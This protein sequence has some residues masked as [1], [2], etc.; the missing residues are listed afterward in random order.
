MMSNLFQSLTF[1]LY[2][3]IILFVVILY[4]FEWLIRKTVPYTKEI[5]RVLG[6]NLLGLLFILYIIFY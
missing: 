3:K 6:I 1:N 4:G 5:F 2:L